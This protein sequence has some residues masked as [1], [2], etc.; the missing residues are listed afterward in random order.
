MHVWLFRDTN[1][2]LSI[3]EVIR[4]LVAWN[5]C[6]RLGWGPNM[7]LGCNLPVSDWFK[8]TIRDALGA[9]NHTHLHFR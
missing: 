1:V 2:I 5:E 7:L 6:F 9:E 4:A 8:D 3:Q